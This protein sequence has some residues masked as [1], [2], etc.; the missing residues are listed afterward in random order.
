MSGTASVSVR[1][2]DLI[3]QALAAGV[4][5]RQ[6]LRHIQVGRATEVSALIKDIERIASDGAAV[7]F[8]I[9]EY[10]SGKTFFL[11]LIKLIAL[12]RKLVTIQGDLGPDRRLLGGTVRHAVY[13]RKPLGTWRPG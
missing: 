8:V 4:V 2:R 13:M 12:E 6:G 3:M 10:G 9:G 11:N 7:R 5:P 1:D